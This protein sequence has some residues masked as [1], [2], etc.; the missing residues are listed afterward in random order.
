[1]PIGYRK[2]NLEDIFSLVLSKYK[3]YHP[4]RNLKF[5]NLGFFRS[6]KLRKLMREIL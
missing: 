5:N 3:K 2:K 1:M 4:S 6:L